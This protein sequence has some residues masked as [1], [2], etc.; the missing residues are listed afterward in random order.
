MRLGGDEFVVLL[1]DQPKDIDAISATIQKLAS[2]VAE[3]VNLDGHELRVTASM[4]IANY[5]SDGTDADTLL[6]NADAAMYRAKAAGRDNFR[7]YTPELNTRVHEKFLLQEQLRNAVARSEFV[8][9]LSAA[10]RPAVRAGLRRR[11]VDTV[12]AP[13]FGFGA[14]DQ[15][16]P[17]RR[18]NRTDCA[19]G[20]VGATRGVP[21]EQGLASG[22][23]ALHPR[24]GKR[25]GAT[26]QRQG[27]VRQGRPRIAR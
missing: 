21:A 3:P 12:E 23:A 4:G 8:L 26:I 25:L 24:F 5:P 15:I 27:P 18:R 1:L 10:S 11:S 6:A 20:R 17:A 7:F 9:F 13:D 2:A 22:R 16:R 14:A 19:D